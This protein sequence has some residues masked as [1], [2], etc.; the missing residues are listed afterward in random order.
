MADMAAGCEAAGTKYNETEYLAEQLS[1][2]RAAP[3]S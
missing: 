3:R 1:V 2:V